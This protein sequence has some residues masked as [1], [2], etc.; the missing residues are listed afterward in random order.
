MDKQATIGFI[1]IGI[2]LVAWMWLQ[3]PQVPPQAPARQDSTHAAAQDTIKKPSPP[4]QTRA[5]TVS[6][7]DAPS[8]FFASRRQGT[9]RILTIRTDLY[10]AELS[11]RGGLLRTWELTKYLTWDKRPVQLV[12]YA[13]GG[14][15][16]LLFTSSDGKLVNTR[17]FFFDIAGAPGNVID[18]TGGGTASVDM[19]LPIATGGRIVKR[20]TFTNG[21]YQFDVDLTMEG[22][23]SVVSN[24]EYQIVWEHG[25]RYAEQNSVDESGFTGAEALSGGEMV[26]IDARTPGEPQKL[27]VTGAT[28][29]VSTHTKYFTLAMLAEEGKTQGAYLEGHA[30]AAPNNG[31]VETYTVALKMPYRGG[32]GESSKVQVYLGPMDY[33]TLRNYGRGLDQTISLGARWIIRPIAQY[34][35]IPLFE[36]LHSFIANYGLVILLFSVIIKVILHP[37]TRTSMRSMRKLQ[38][39]Q[40]MMNEIREK[41]KGD[42]EKMGQAQMNLYKEYGINPASG[43]LPLLLQMPILFALYQVFRSTIGLR[44][45]E[46]VG[47]ITDLSIPDAIVHLPFTVPFF[48][49]TQISGITLAMGATMFVQQRMTPTDPRNKAMVW[50]M[51]LLFMLMFNNLP[52]GLNLYYFIF[53]LLSIGQQYLFNRQHKDEPLRKVEPKKKQGGILGR[54]SKDLPKVRQR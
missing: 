43:C 5:D 34:F 24:F 25:L 17:A 26:E 53:N 18:L 12:D 46:F 30:A 45:A 54:I 22:A 3:A 9:E 40:P 10:T 11:T 13:S 23:A 21:T 32:A 52:S 44:Q 41:Y 16:S 19:V 35:M 51:P 6:R 48:G 4:A 28:S 2:V 42:T 39:L 31:L 20:F 49:I 7:I 15:F 14:D 47:W 27:D 29:W 8:Q 38:A 50:L 33:R 36:F 1:L 37:L